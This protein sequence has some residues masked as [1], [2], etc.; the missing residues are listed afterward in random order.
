MTNGGM[1]DGDAK[2]SPFG[3]KMKLNCCKVTVLDVLRVHFYA[4]RVCTGHAVGS[5]T[6]LFGM[7]KES[8][9]QVLLIAGILHRHG[10]ATHF[11]EDKFK[12]GCELLMGGTPKGIEAA[13]YSLADPDQKATHTTKA[14]KP[15]QWFVRIGLST[16]TRD[17]KPY[18]NAHKQL[19]DGVRPPR[20]SLN[21]SRQLFKEYESICNS[22]LDELYTSNTK[23]ATET[24]RDAKDSSRDPSSPH[25]ARQSVHP[26]TQQL[27]HQHLL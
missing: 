17:W 20:A 3:R 15:T 8:F 11:S 5:K 2:R 10:G 27:L 24:R 9:V 22:L 21:L 16:S 23:K 18:A 6:H 19:K 13:P 26:R 14:R 12:Q 1:R 7:S 4:Y 25:V